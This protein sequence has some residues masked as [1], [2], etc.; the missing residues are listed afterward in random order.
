MPPVLPNCSISFVRPFSLPFGV[1]PETVAGTDLAHYQ[2]ELGLQLDFFSLAWDAADPFI[3]AEHPRD[4]F[5][6]ALRARFMRNNSVVGAVTV[7]TSFNPPSIA[8]TDIHTISFASN[9]LDQ[10]GNKA[11]KALKT[12]GSESMSSAMARNFRWDENER[13]L[14]ALP[15]PYF[16]DET[17]C[18]YFPRSPAPTGAL[19]ID[20]PGIFAD[21]AS[22]HLL[23][24]N[25]EARDGELQ[26]E[27]LRSPVRGLARF[28][29]YRHIG[30]TESGGKLS[31]PTMLAP[32]AAGAVVL[33]ALPPSSAVP[34]DSAAPLIRDTFLVFEHISITEASTCIAGLLW[35]Q[36]LR[37]T[38]LESIEQLKKEIRTSTAWTFAVY[39]ALATLQPQ[40]VDALGGLADATRDK[41]KEVTSTPDLIALRAAILYVLGDPGRRSAFTDY[42]R[43]TLA[44]LACGI[45]WGELTDDAGNLRYPGIPADPGARTTPNKVAH[46]LLE[47]VQQANDIWIAVYAGAPI[48]RSAARYRTPPS[49]APVSDVARNGFTTFDVEALVLAGRAAAAFPAVIPPLGPAS[50]DQTVDLTAYAGEVAGQ[51]AAI[52]IA[53]AAPGSIAFT[54]RDWLRHLVFG[55]QRTKSV[56]A[57][58]DFLNMAVAG[59]P[60]TMALFWDRRMKARDLRKSLDD[61]ALATNSAGESLDQAA[62]KWWINAVDF[63]T[64][65]AGIAGTTTR[66]EF[67][68]LQ[69]PGTGPPVKDVL[70]E[71]PS[72]AG[73]TAKGAAVPSGFDEEDIELA[74]EARE[75][76][77]SGHDLSQQVDIALILAL[78]DREGYRMRGPYMRQGPFDNEYREN[79]NILQRRHFLDAPSPPRRGLSRRGASQGIGRFFYALQVF[80]LDILDWRWIPKNSPA[81]PTAA[82]N[83][84]AAKDHWLRFA[85]DNLV[86]LTTDAITKGTVI[87]IDTRA[88]NGQMLVRM[89]SK[90][91]LPPTAIGKSRLLSRR[92]HLGGII[93]QHGEFQRRHALLREGAAAGPLNDSW[94]PGSGT[95]LPDV[96]Q[97]TAAPAPITGAN[98]EDTARRDYLAY[99]A[100]CYLA[101]NGSPSVWKS[102]VTRASNL[103]AANIPHFLLYEITDAQAAGGERELWHRG[104]FA[105]FAVALDAYLRMSNTGAGD[106]VFPM[107]AGWGV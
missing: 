55:W 101:F 83:W 66:S 50:R 14:W 11:W 74:I 89:A 97:F 96:T 98:A 64:N 80:G 2:R 43:T 9:A 41:L 46:A 77:R 88:L 99:Y 39:I 48:G 54:M 59:H 102:W 36:I 70:K 17:L 78:L 75:H 35:L 71:A 28:T 51:F 62:V 84:F 26:R 61:A 65:A 31:A 86:T 47:A 93:V 45:G 8:A 40:A 25:A 90:F 106:V 33:R 49:G 73:K 85:W 100:L 32:S 29:R 87:G 44:P 1:P 22:S 24:T 5:T 58:L 69:L 82:E 52:R 4:P 38:E 94:Q 79:L 95:V 105:R 19:G 60:L 104:H 23:A 34:A 53:D 13:K 92:A 91:D 7:P 12:T 81:N 21:D 10:V 37:F 30:F 15:Q 6:G 3:S 42:L 27:L 63:S 76:L 103:G 72:R 16:G 56:D 107:R 67:W 18:L 20:I 68:P 57:P